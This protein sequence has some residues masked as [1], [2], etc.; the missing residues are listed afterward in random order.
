V[1]WPQ[2]LG[3][4]YFLAAYAELPKVVASLDIFG[5]PARLLHALGLGF[6]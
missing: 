1:A 3:H 4:H 5:D 6:W 2:V